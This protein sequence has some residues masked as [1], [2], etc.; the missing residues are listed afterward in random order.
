MGGF[1]LLLGVLLWTRGVSPAQTRLART[2]STAAAKV[3]EA[4]TLSFRITS[5]RFEGTY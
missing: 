5:S 2:V 4:S 1:L 3:K